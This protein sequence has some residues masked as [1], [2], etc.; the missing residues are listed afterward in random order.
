MQPTQF[1]SGDVI[2]DRRADYAR[3][4]AESGDP[5][6]AAEL[7]E[8][9]LEL[10]PAWAA[11]WLRL[12]EYREKAGLGGQAAE[13]LRQVLA[14]DPEDIF[15][16]GLKLALLGAVETPDR[17]PSRYVE[18]LFDDYADRFEAAL[19]ERLDYS[20]PGKLA[21]LVRKV[22][23]E[24]GPFACA[25]DLGCGTGLFGVEIRETVRRL[26]GF[27]LSANMLTKAE[28]KGIYDHLARS[29]LSRD[30]EGSQ[31]FA[32][33]LARGR[34]ELVAAADVLMY[35]GDLSNAFS[36]GAELAEPG[37]LFAFSVEDAGTPEGFHLAPSLR[38][39]HSETYVR[40]ALA[41]AGFQIC[42]IERTIIRMDGG[43]PVLGILFVAI[44]TR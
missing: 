23:G 3:M 21:V 32:D 18:A 7:M 4:L 31:L 17:P 38:Y 27:D 20:V 14:L 2:A 40:A 11:G 28:E 39:A 30:A 10:A 25:I 16:A 6:A 35:L 34:A 37:A 24:G 13:A 22:R 42:E 9:A 41:A 15:G 26:E 36:L 19:V 33:G 5:A 44:R 8:Q 43:K 1:S 29:D 12:G